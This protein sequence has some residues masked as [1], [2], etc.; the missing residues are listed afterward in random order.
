VWGRWSKFN[1]AID[2]LFKVLAKR[3]TAHAHHEQ[4]PQGIDFAS[5][6]CASLC[7]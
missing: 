1:A 5:F 6:V 2:S 7:T 4:P 3:C